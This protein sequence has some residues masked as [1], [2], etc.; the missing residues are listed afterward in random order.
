MLHLTMLTLVNECFITD[1]NQLL[2]LKSFVEYMIL[3]YSRVG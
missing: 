2:F 3:R 1:Y